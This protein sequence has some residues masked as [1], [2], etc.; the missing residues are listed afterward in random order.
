VEIA[1]PTSIEDSMGIIGSSIGKIQGAE[2]KRN[3]A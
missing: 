1:A 3:Q 2:R